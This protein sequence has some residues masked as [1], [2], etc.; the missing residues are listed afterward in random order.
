MYT[1]LPI[2]AKT[3]VPPEKNHAASGHEIVEF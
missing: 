2:R 3:S 1:M